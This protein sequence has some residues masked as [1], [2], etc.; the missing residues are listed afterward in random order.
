MSRSDRS[1]LKPST[2][3]GSLIFA[4]LCLLLIGASYRVRDMQVFVAC[5][6]V[7]AAIVAITCY[8]A[9]VSTVSKR[10]AR[11][12]DIG[13]H[14]CGPSRIRRVGACPD[15]H[16]RSPADERCEVRR[17]SFDSH[18]VTYNMGESADPENLR[19]FLNASDLDGMDTA[20]LTRLCAAFRHRPYTAL[21]ALGRECQRD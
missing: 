16:Q 10:G 3:Y 13:S 19:E 8:I 17:V 12:L 21:N 2:Y 14:P 1:K 5:F 18:G 7:G 6:S 15:T 9:L 4:M 11:D 20:S